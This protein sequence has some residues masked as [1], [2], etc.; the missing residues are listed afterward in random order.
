M[1]RRRDQAEDLLDLLVALRGTVEA[2]S[3]RSVSSLRRINLLDL[4]LS[5]FIR[6]YAGTPVP[7]A[8]NER[9]SFR[10]D[11]VIVEMRALLTAHT[12]AINV[13]DM[14]C[15]EGNVARCVMESIGTDASRVHIW[16]VDGNAGCIE[17]LQNA[18]SE[19]RQLASFT[20]VVRV[21]PDVGVCEDAMV[22]A[23]ILNNALHEIPPRH[24]G[25]MFLNFDRLLNK[26]TGRVYIIDMSELPDDA[27]ESIAVTWAGDEVCAF[28]SAGGLECH[29]TIHDKSVSVYRVVVEPCKR[30][31]RSGAIDQAV[32]RLLMR[33]QEIAIERL[34]AIRREIRETPEGMRQW[35]VAVGTVAR[36]ADEVDHMRRS[37]SVVPAANPA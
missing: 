10:E 32:L 6:G 31:V 5:E 23:I 34:R 11:S 16:A 13:I 35:V 15:G 8:L 33:K 2:G 21:I 24:F 27:P 37:M 14:C 4:Q 17:A 9:T 19:F 22:D 28:L 20:P 29:S 12:R 7:V 18:A 25:T 36:I 1:A 3:D 30:P 26:E